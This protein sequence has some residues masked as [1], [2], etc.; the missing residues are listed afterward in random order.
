MDV[1]LVVSKGAMWV[2]W[3]DGSMAGYSAACSAVCWVALTVLML[4]PSS[5]V[6]LVAWKDTLMVVMLAVY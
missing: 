3:K 5:D 6:K 1:Q 4:A 2:V